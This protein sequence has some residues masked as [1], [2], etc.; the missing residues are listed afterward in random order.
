MYSS[1]EVKYKDFDF[2]MIIKFYT[3]S[4]KEKLQKFSFHYDN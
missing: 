4:F 1:L 3:P 2:A